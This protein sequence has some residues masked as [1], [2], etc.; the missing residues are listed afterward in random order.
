MPCQPCSMKK[1]TPHQGLSAF[2]T[3]GLPLML[4][5]P[6]RGQRQEPEHD[7]RPE[8]LA[9]QVGA[10]PLRGEQQQQHA[11]RDRQHPAVQR[12]RGHLEALDRRQH[13]DRRRQ[14]AVAEEQRD[15]E[16][17]EDA[18]QV[19]RFRCLRQRALRQCRERHDAAFALVVGAHDHQHVLHR[20]HDHQRPEHQR[21]DAEHRGVVGRQAVVRRERFLDRVQRAGADVAEHDADRAEH[22]GAEAGLADIGSAASR[23]GLAA[24]MA[25]RG[26]SWIGTRSWDGEG[27]GRNDCPGGD[28]SVRRRRV[29]D[30]AARGRRAVNSA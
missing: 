30:E 6:M 9:D 18:D 28:A 11:D 25:A 12:R 17:A 14:H 2:S 3:S 24:C 5:M 7:D 22:H 15:A 19:G 13:R 21:Q 23:Q 1:R 29:N 8:C 27:R 10:E 20:D 26:G 16:H 4:R